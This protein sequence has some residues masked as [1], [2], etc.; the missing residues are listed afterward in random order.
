MYFRYQA[1]MILDSKTEVAGSHPGV[2]IIFIFKKKIFY[3]ILLIDKLITTYS[4]AVDLDTLLSPR[5]SF[6]IKT[7]LEIAFAVFGCQI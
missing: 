1:A 6:R 7:F 4:K 5:P 2:D 3:N